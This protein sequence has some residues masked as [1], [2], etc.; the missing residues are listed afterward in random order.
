M[1]DAFR[2]NSDPACHKH[3][4]Q[5]IHMTEIE[6]THTEKHPTA[7]GYSPVASKNYRRPGQAAHSE[8]K[9]SVSP[10]L[11]EVLSLLKT[12]DAAA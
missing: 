7:Q 5:N 12:L 11:N 1:N 6:M 9:K 8:T 3:H 2:E 4:H 10:G